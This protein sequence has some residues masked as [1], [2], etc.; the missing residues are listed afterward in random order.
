MLGGGLG[1]GARVFAL[2]L[3]PV[4]RRA[5]DV[6]R[7]VAQARIAV[8]ASPGT[9]TEEDLARTSFKSVLH[10]DGIVARVEYKQGTSGGL[11]L[12]GAV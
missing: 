4:A 10:L 7:R 11:S 1:S 6:L 9:Q 12:V 2:H 3:G 5:S 8:E